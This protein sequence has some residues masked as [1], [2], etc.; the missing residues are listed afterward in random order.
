[1][2]DQVTFHLPQSGIVDHRSPPEAKIALFRSL[3]RGRE[4][5]Y[6][7]RFESRRTGKSGYQP[8]CGNEWVRGV[9]EKPRIKCSDCPHQRF[10]P[11]TDD[12][13]RWHLSG[14]DDQ[15]NDFVM[16]IYPMLQ[17]ETCFI[18]AVDFDGQGWRE[19]ANAFCQTCIGLNAPA[20]LERS[21]SGNGAHVWIFF[22][23]A[24]SASLARKLGCHILTETMERRPEIGLKSYDRLFPN[25]DTLPMGGFGSLIALPLQK[26]ARE[27]GNSVFVDRELIPYPDQ[28]AFLSSVRRIEQSSVESIVEQAEA[29][30]R[31]V[32]IRHAVT[33]ED[34]PAPW[35]L[36][37]SRRSKE[38]AV[39]GPLPE[40]L[41]LVLSDEIYIAKDVLS[42][43]L[44]NRIVRLAAFQNPEFYK[45]QAMRLPTYDKPR[46]IGCAED[47]A[48]HIGLPR[49]CLSDLLELLSETGIKHRI[50][51]ERFSGQPLEV[52]FRGE[53]RQE[54]L[55]AATAMLGHDMGV[56]SAST[57][58][59]KTVVAAWL[60]AKR[61][62]STLVLVH[63]RQLL[64][65]W[66][67]RLSAFLDV[68]RTAIGQIGGG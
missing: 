65:Q 3:F 56:L 17:N 7:R 39:C 10:L 11:I 38:P 61:S 52:E 59:G 46:I 22:D 24:I 41:E 23:A 47:H 68:Q 45:S 30:N 62:V 49:G 53:L 42:P 54:Q 48:H 29:G 67:E 63:R 36:P 40:N 44:R 35:A 16:G 28:W 13:I 12:V 60:I 64:E 21:R 18:L 2:L 25:Q 14:A 43:A 55:T 66:I 9:C 6:P 15:D 33:E 4:E 27:L 50:R 26:R 58:F 57:A 37:P 31:V 8:A 32:G 19:D 1:M 20:A 51:D 5:V 34:G